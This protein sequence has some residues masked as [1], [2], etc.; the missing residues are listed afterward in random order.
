VVTPISTALRVATKIVT[1][2]AADVGVAWVVSEP[3]PRKIRRRVWEI[4]WGGSVH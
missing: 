1:L 4:G 3:D 2:Y